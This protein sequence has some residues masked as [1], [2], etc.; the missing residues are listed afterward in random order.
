MDPMSDANCLQRKVQEAT[1]RRHQAGEQRTR[2][3]GRNRLRPDLL[4]LE[5]RRLMATFVVSNPSDTLTK[6]V[7]TPYTLRWAVDQADA[8]T[9]ASKIVFQLPTIGPATITLTQ[10]EL[11]LSN[12]SESVTITGLGADELTVDGNGASQ[13][14]A[15][16]PGVTASI[17]GLSVT[18]G[19]TKAG[20][21]ASD[22]G[23][24]VL[25][26]GDLTLIGVTV[27]HNT[28]TGFIVPFL[29]GGGLDNLGVATVVG[30]TFADNAGVDGGGVSNGGTA[31]L[32][33]CSFVDNTAVFSGGGMANY[34]LATLD[35][36][37]FV[38]NTSQ[39]AEGGGFFGEKLGQPSS[40]ALSNCSFIDNTAGLNG[41]GLGFRA[42]D[43]GP[44]QFTDCVIRDNQAVTGGGRV[45]HRQQC[46]D[47]DVHWLPHRG[48]SRYSPPNRRGRRR[49]RPGSVRCRHDAHRLHRQQQ[50]HQWVRWRVGG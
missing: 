16:D 48:Q 35:G 5:E 12:M 14:F 8:A 24:G 42:Y 17:S 2:L 33:D 9:S 38:G 32:R 15:I 41:G 50:P 49:W 39:I 11:D 22:A 36:C 47:G 26:Q 46:D 31:T 18:G 23:A 19:F 25:N 29:P 37:S 28:T 4:A 21:L 1:T 7:P 13:V 45:L 20:G 44:L 30:C 40:S 3:A 10:G 34:G 43:S 27:D 6:G